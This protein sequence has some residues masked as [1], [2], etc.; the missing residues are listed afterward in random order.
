MTT[1]HTPGPWR[2]GTKILDA[3][4]AGDRPICG[5]AYTMCKD[6]ERM[7]N[8]RLIAAAPDLLA[9]LEGAIRLIDETWAGCERP[10][11]IAA[12]ATLAKA[13]AKGE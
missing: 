7:A 4:F 2:T 11:L 9:A 13:R 10:E 1:N 6:D 3:V 8:A 5:P 12:R